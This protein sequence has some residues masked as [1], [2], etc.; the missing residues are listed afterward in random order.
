MKYLLFV[1]V[2]MAFTQSAVASKKG[3]GTVYEVD[4]R[5][6][7][8]HWSGSGL[9]GRHTGYVLIGSSS[10]K[11]QKDKLVEGHVE[12]DLNTIDCRNYEFQDWNEQLVDHLKSDDFFAV[13]KYPSAEF[14]LTTIEKTEDPMVYTIKG[15]LGLKGITNDISFPA[16][17]HISNDKL[18]VL[19]TASIDRTQW[20]IKFASGRFFKNLG[21]ELINDEIEI[22]FELVAKPV[23]DLASN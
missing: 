20:G 12:L 22:E 8:V 17:I 15:E 19:G 14:S 18:L 21:D 1:F 13:D 23:E 7:V 2:V 3:E 4:K 11:T 9:A 5:S 6:S 16:R 10:F